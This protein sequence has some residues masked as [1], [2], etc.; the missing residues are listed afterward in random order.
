MLETSSR[1]PT[2]F[3]LPQSH[4]Q[5]AAS[6]PSVAEIA[7]NTK[8]NPDAKFPDHQGKWTE[9]ASASEERGSKSCS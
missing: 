7:A 5:M 1:L 6:T 2:T 3:F 9:R 8:L 4:N